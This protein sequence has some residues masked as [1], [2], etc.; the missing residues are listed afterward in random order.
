MNR[1]VVTGMGALTP[2]GNS[3]PEFWENAVN[4]VNGIDRIT[5]FDTTNLKYKFAGE[6]KNVDFTGVIEKSQL[7]KMDLF[8]Q[9]A[10]YAA[11]EAVKD[12]GIVGNVD[13][14]RFGVYFGT[15][16]GGFDT[17]CADHTT[18]LELFI[19]ERGDYPEDDR[20]H[21][22][23]KHRYQI[24]RSRSKYVRINCVRNGRNGYRR[25]LP[26]NKA[27]LRRR[28]YMRRQRGYHQSLGCGRVRQYE[29]SLDSRNKRN[30]VYSV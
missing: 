11:D 30:R 13:E 15:G 2:I 20:K 29:G 7:R 5:R 14:T 1:V 16:V 9:Y 26:S 12:S 28:C 3:V 18:L 10:L 8:T 19:G 17:F 23:R 21:R 24:S 6:V 27:R 4:G 25:S 22:R